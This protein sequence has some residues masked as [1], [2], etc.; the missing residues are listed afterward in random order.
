VK[1]TVT[2]A[3]WRPVAYSLLAIPMVILA[4]DMLFTYRFVPGPDSTE[5]PAVR[6]ME[7]GSTVDTTLVVLTNDGSA[8][9]RRDIVWGSA[10]LGGGVLAAAWGLKDLLFPRKVISI[11]PDR[12]TLRVSRRISRAA[13]FSWNEIAE[14]RSGIL[15]DEAGPAPVLSLRFVDEGLVPVDPWGAVADP[16]WLHLYATEWDRQAHEVAPMIEA[17]VTRF[18][19][20][21]AQADDS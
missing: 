12:L 10:L 2:R 8:Q 1:V 18:R 15:E 7:D 5:V 14:A 9:R 21:P 17:Y 19:E 13:H 4:V 6:T 16:P 3:A 11:G 20:A